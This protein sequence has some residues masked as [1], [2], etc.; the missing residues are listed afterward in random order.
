M[1]KKLE[2]VIFTVVIVGLIFEKKKFFGQNSSESGCFRDWVLVSIA[3]NCT[4]S[5]SDL[6]VKKTSRFNF[7]RVWKVPLFSSFGFINL[8]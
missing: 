8:Q 2:N 3:Q 6:S 7:C 4:K 1:P 5:F